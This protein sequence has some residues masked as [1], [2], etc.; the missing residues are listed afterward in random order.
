MLLYPLLLTTSVKSYEA[1]FLGAITHNGKIVT[2]N[3]ARCP[4][5]DTVSIISKAFAPYVLK[6]MA[7]TTNADRIRV[8]CQFR[9]QKSD[10]VISMMVSTNVVRTKTLLDTLAKHPKV[11]AHPA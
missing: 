6:K 1:E 2:R 7:I 3:S 11:E 5:K 4:N 8:Y 10:W 9:K